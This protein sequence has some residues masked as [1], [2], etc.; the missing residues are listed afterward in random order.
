MPSGKPIDQLFIRVETDLKAV[1]RDLDKLDRRID[2]SQ[3]SAS[4]SFSSLQKLIT[5]GFTIVIGRALLSAGQEALDFAS[6]IEEM[7]SK[8]KVVFGDFRNDVINSLDEFSRKTGR[9]VF[10]LEEMASSI[11]DVLV[12]LGFM[13]E[14]AS[15]LSVDIT[16]L[17]TDLAS[18]NNAAD[19]EVVDNIKSAILGQGLA[20]KKYGIVITEARIQQEAYA[21]GL[22]K[23]TRAMT[24]QEKAGIILKIL[25]ADTS[26]AQGDAVKTAESYENQVKAMEAQQLRF[27][28]ELGES[29]RG[30][31][32]FYNTLKKNFFSTLADNLDFSQTLKLSS[33]LDV[34]KI[35]AEELVEV[36][37]VLQNTVKGDL[38]KRHEILSNAGGIAFDIGYDPEKLKKLKKDISDIEKILSSPEFEERFGSE[39]QAAVTEND[40]ALSILA[41]QTLKKLEDQNYV[42]SLIEQGFDKSVANSLVRAGFSEADE[43]TDNFN[44][45]KDVA[46]EV[47]LN[48]KN[49]ESNK[50]LKTAND[51]LAKSIKILDLQSQGYTETQLD[52]LEAAG[53]LDKA[54]SKEAESLIKLVKLNDEKIKESELQSDI[55][56]QLDKYNLKLQ[57]QVLL[58]DGLTESQIEALTVGDRIIDHESERG[59]SILNVHDSLKK[60]TD[61][62][63]A[64]IEAQEDLEDAQ[65]DAVGER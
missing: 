8:S 25:Y 33:Q 65:E 58:R 64:Q 27:N 47:E 35:K 51:D 11:Q 26:D 45:I 3:K 21:L 32:L 29:L 2:K 6:K 28:K 34:S 5:A 24:A 37:G 13:R 57:E 50:K 40:K 42:L 41:S 59:K 46:I 4:K 14:E 19:A 1:K 38:F 16:K 22:K 18:F 63:E 62:T 36:L 61:Q 55:N 17:S 53:L 49:S 54:H 31:G 30:L 23:S 10:D 56:D 60:L 7:Q 43:G 9:S 12:P 48:K 20:V 52:A 44:K 15:K 39:T